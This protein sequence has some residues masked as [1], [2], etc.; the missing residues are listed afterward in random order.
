MGQLKLFDCE[1][2]QEPVNVASVPMRSPFRYPGGK[3]WFVPYARRWLRLLGGRVE[4]IEP[5]TGG[6]IVSLTACFEG[7]VKKAIMVEKD[8]NIASA[9]RTILGRDRDW[10]I[11]Q[12]ATVEIEPENVQHLLRRHPHSMRERAFQTILRNRISHGGIL[13]DGAGLIKNGEN[14]KG[15]TS[16]WYPETLKRRIADI[17]IIANRL[18]F[19]EGDGL[20]VMEHNVNRKD[21]AFFIDPPYTKA[22]RRLY[23]YHQID[24]KRLFD[25]VKQIKGDFLVTYDAAPEIEVMAEK[26]NLD[27][28]K[29]LMK[30]THHLRKYELVIGRDLGWLREMLAT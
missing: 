4:L 2:L 30:T 12:I 15:L 18:E 10:L 29:V 9:W 14:G 16:R 5:F 6:G 7:L 23:K 27:I 20:K 11:H 21:V 22:G 13:A 1:T 17:A 28:E 8:E 24:H 19:I 26:Q 3:T 25:I